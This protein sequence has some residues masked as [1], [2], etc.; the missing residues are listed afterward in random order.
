MHYFLLAALG[1]THSVV[2]LQLSH[3]W[4]FHF[5]CDYICIPTDYC[6]ILQISE[7]NYP[8]DINIRIL[9]FFIYK[10]L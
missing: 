10:I 5:D 7:N 1:Q 6:S 3:A 4:S 8:G 9:D 2:Q